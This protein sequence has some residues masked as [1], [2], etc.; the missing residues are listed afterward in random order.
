MSVVDDC[1]LFDFAHD[2]TCT[3]KCYVVACVK[4]YDSSGTYITIKIFKKH[5]FR[6]QTQNKKKQLQQ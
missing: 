4:T 5:N 2:I 6:D 1:S 3:E